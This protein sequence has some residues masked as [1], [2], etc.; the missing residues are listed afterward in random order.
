MSDPKFRVYYGKPD[1]GTASPDME[2]YLQDGTAYAGT[3]S[4]YFDTAPHEAWH[5]RGYTYYRTE[6]TG[7]NLSTPT[8]YAEVS[9]NFLGGYRLIAEFLGYESTGTG[10]DYMYSSSLSYTNYGYIKFEISDP[11]HEL[12]SAEAKKFKVEFYLVDTSDNHTLIDDTEFSTDYVNTPFPKLFYIGRPDIVYAVE[13][14]RPSFKIY[15]GWF[16]DTPA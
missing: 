15:G 7:A 9:V 5:S 4:H 3:Q 13:D 2:L 10:V 1:N 16:E 11:D 6:P 14:Y 12:S 8:G